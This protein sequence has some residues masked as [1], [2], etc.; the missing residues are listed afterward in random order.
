M[1]A[2]SFDP[3]HLGPR[4]CIHTRPTSERDDIIVDWYLP[5]KSCEVTASPRG[6]GRN[7]NVVLVKAGHLSGK[8]P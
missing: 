6:D 4:K 7:A 3:G 1:E 8:E 2:E 5:E